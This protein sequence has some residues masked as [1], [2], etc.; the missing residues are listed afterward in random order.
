MIVQTTDIVSNGVEVLR[1]VTAIERGVY[2]DETVH[3]QIAA[4]SDLLAMEAKK[5]GATHVIGVQFMPYTDD[6]GRKIIR[7]VGTAVRKNNGRS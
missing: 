4:L 3:M 6:Y 1:L 2:S 5:V 7:A